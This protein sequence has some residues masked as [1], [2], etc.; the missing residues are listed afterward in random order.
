MR[1]TCPAHLILLD[2]ICL[3]MSGDEYKL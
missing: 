3:M 1:V 2:F